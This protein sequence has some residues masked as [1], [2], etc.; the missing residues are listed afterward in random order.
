MIRRFFPAV[1]V[2]CVAVTAAL[3][4]VYSRSLPVLD[5]AARAEVF[6]KERGTLRE[7]LLEAHPD[8]SAQTSQGLVETSWKLYQKEHRLDLRHKVEERTRELKERYRDEAGQA[9]MGGIDSYHWLRHLK[10]LYATGHVGDRVEDGAEYDALGSRPVDAS[11]RRNVHLYLAWPLA[12]LAERLHL[13]LTPVLFVLPVMMFFVI[14]GCSFACAKRIGANDLGA[15]FAAFSITLSPF[16]LSRVFTEWFDTDIYSVFFPLAILTSYLAC[17]DLRVGLR[18]RLVRALLGGAL[19]ALYAST[20]QGWWFIFDIIIIASALYLVNL[21][22][23]RRFTEE[24]PADV[25]AQARMFGAFFGFSAV[26]VMLLNGPAVFADFILEPVRLTRIFNIAPESIWPNVYLTVE[27]LSPASVPLVVQSIGGSFIF[28]MGLIGLLFAFVRERLL[29]DTVF[30]C[31]LLC[32]AIWIVVSFYAALQALRLVLLLIVPAG[33]AFGFVV[34]K[35]RDA[36]ENLVS[37]QGVRP[38]VRL[39]GRG[40]FL[41]LAA[42]YLFSHTT[43]VYGTATTTLPK[44]NDIWQRTLA[45]IHDAAPTE[46]VV[47]SWWD[48]GHWF[49]TVAGRRVLFDGMTQNSPY[50]YW[51]AQVLFSDDEGAAARTLKMLDAS[52]HEGVDLLV[53]KLGGVGEAVRLTQTVLAAG[54][55][56]GRAELTKA[57]EPADVEAAMP[58]L[59][60]ETAPPAYFILSYDMLSKVAPISFIANWDFSRVDMWFKGRRLGEIEFLEYAQRQHNL[61]PGQA[62]ATH[63]DVKA[64]N[65]KAARSW[66]SKMVGYRSDLRPLEAWQGMWMFENGLIVDWSVKRAYVMGGAPDG[67]GVPASLLYMEDGVFHEEPQPGAT[68]DFSALIVRQDEEIKAILLPPALGKSLLLRLYFLKGEGLKHFRLWNEETDEN[69]NAIYVYEILWPE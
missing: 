17:I 61:T 20:W 65:E 5:K 35:I 40:A 37:R 22:D 62:M 54:P 52:G 41:I 28:F 1:L 32:A 39:A 33:L 27:E 10:N 25:G 19:V 31:G 8:L 45:R 50:A 66:F 2:L 51:M 38:A 23:V 6:D 67:R 48:F 7:T 53:E 11:T 30:G 12:W 43:R 42:L 15:F 56:K 49:K 58:L 69:D 63:W 46:S 57:L 4:L 59:F 34:G 47:N 55:E 3:L 13:P 64:L 60:P 18:R 21:K 68:L 24:E 16:L 44:F 36:V 14:A 29:R 9:Y 26:C